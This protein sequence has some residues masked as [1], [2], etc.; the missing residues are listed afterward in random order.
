MITNRQILKDILQKEQYEKLMECFKTAK[1]ICD[2]DI[3]DTIQEYEQWL[4][5]EVQ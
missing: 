2:D 4:D 1:T 5:S 3:I